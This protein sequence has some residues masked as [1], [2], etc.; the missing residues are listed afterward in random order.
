VYLIGTTRSTK[1][2]WQR[3]YK[4][5]SSG[6]SLKLKG[7]VLF[8]NCPNY[9]ELLQLIGK[10]FFVTKLAYSVFVG[11]GGGAPAS[12]QFRE[13][14]IPTPAESTQPSVAVDVKHIQG[15]S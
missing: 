10:N 11:W 5:I 6:S 12:H 13:V 15:Y 7:I 4:I 8:P 3:T 9:L 2:C 14:S 1:S